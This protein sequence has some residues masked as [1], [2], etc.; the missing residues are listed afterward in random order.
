MIFNLEIHTIMNTIELVINSFNLLGFIS[1]L[2]I[3]KNLRSSDINYPTKITIFSK[4][5][6]AIYTVYHNHYL[7]SFNIISLITIETLILKY[8]IKPVRK[9]QYQFKYRGP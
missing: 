3:I 2:T 6:F 7:L 9:K 5:C 4:S 8:K 1:G